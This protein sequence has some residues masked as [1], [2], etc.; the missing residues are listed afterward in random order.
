[1]LATGAA[2]P[3]AAALAVVVAWAA[4][5]HRLAGHRV[6]GAMVQRAGAGACLVG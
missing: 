6:M 5:G 4:I 1:M 2:A 3:L